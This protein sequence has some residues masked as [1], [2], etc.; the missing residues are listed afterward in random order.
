MSVTGVGTSGGGGVTVLCLGAGAGR[1][2]VTVGDGVS[3]G[4]E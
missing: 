4:A 2:V 1:L 3:A